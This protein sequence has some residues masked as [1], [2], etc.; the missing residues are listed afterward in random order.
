MYYE[1]MEEILPSLKVIIDSGEGNI[2]KLLPLDSL[3]D[4]E[5]GNE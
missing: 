5:G 4:T 2:N 1:T 3:T